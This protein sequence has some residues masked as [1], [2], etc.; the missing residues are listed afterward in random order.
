MLAAALEKYRVQVSQKFKKT[1]KKETLY[2]ILKRNMIST[3]LKKEKISENIDLR[4]FK[5]VV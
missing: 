3:G 1:E 4:W 2:E 5:L